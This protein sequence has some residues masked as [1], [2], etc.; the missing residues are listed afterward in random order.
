V[1]GQEKKQG[2]QQRYAKQQRRVEEGELHVPEEREADRLR[3][4]HHIQI[5]C[6]PCS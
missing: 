6:L 2:L 5:I 4:F 1:H 3:A